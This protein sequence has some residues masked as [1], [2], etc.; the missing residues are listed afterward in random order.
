MEYSD[1]S[2]KTVIFYISYVKFKKYK[3]NERLA[4]AKNVKDLL[5]DIMVRFVLTVEVLHRFT[6]GLTL[7]IRPFAK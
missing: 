5:L 1:K 3:L 7:Q 6:T 4:N 2:T